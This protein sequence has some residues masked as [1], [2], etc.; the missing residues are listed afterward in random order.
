MKEKRA[1]RLI[2]RFLEIGACLGIFSG[3]LA[4]GNLQLDQFQTPASQQGDSSA[5][6]ETT[7]SGADEGTS[8]LLRKAAQSLQAN[9]LVEAETSA[10][11]YLAKEPASW[12]G[13]FL[14]GSI[15]FRQG[16][17]AESLAEFTE[18]ARSH[19]PEAKDLKIVAL[20]YV[21]LNNY[22]DA[23]KWL[24]MSLTWN[25]NDADAWYYLG[26]T[27]Y[28]ENRF[29]EAIAAFDRCLQLENRHVKAK[30]NLG[31]SLAGLGRVA[32]AQAAYREAIA[33]QSHSK[34]K[35]AEPY[36]DLGD[37]LLNQNQPDEAVSM[38]K[39]AQAIAPE[40]PRVP[41][42]LGKALWRQNKFEDARTQLEEAV[43]LLPGSAA[44][45]YL[46]GQVYR[47]LGLAEKAKSELELAAALSTPQDSRKN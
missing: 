2:A 30:A 44:D 45:H 37:L 36:I 27:K 40:D 5:S 21:L 14:L 32:E 29:A 41:E 3:S 7:Q 42:L 25:P 9:R 38:L 6:R 11:A 13:H 18:G 10:R 22:P 19:E 35:I 16:H 23:D 1:S 20:D 24:T 17:A 33:W 47:K 43:R 39:Q 15:L 12:E 28:S 26:R 31:L 46:L 8:A 4:P 34:V